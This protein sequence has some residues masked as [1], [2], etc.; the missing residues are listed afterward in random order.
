MDKK[1]YILIAILV[2]LTIVY[3]SVAMWYSHT[4]AKYTSS[5][6]SIQRLLT[7]RREVLSSS[8]QALAIN[9]SYKSVCNSIIPPNNTIVPYNTIPQNTTALVNWRP[10]T[11]RLTGYLNGINSALNGV[12]DMNMGVALALE[13]GARA[14]VFDIDYLEDSPCNPVIIHRDDNGIM[15]SL[16]VGSIRNGCTALANNAFRNNNDPVIIILYLR[17]YPQSP[18]SE[19]FQKYFGN[20]AAALKPLA[21]Y[22]LGSNGQGNFHNCANE[23]NLFTSPI[24]NYQKNFIILTNYDTTQLAHTPNP[25][26]NLN[27]WTN[28]RIW[29]DPNGKSSTL[30]S[31][32][33][34][35]PASPPP[36]AQVGAVSQLLNIGTI[37]MPN[38]IHGNTASSSNT[39]K[40]ALGDINTPI[41]VKDMNTLLNLL[42]I[43]CVPI[44]VLG[45]ASVPIHAKT[46]I[47]TPITITD[48]ATYTTSA[49][50][51][52]FWGMQ[53]GWS[54]KYMNGDSTVDSNTQQFPVLTIQ[55]FIIPTATP[56]SAPSRST[57]A[58]GGSIPSPQ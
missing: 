12:F 20:I 43:Q 18:G 53:S 7:I 29:L 46:K 32:T 39:F 48:L 41:S 27:F 5:P 16:H 52:S 54:R 9:N 44:D 49:D 35:A 22:H 55:G 33:S 56:P 57:N 30:G 24:T 10:M 11:V 3:F 25:T 26:D 34:A 14:F 1:T 47:G 36:Y 6:A 50:V 21:M 28:A 4:Y 2:V 8:I 51:L 13:Q 40:I 23:A 38:Y 37:D 31:V 58:A 19:Q 42:G 15:R 45:L 17:R